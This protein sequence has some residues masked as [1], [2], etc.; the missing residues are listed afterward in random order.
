MLN[1]LDKFRDGETGE[2]ICQS[3]VIQLKGHKHYASRNV[4]ESKKNEVRR[5]IMMEMREL[6]RL[7][8]RFRDLSSKEV[9]V[10]S[11]YEREN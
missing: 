10:E 11:M 3:S 1:I 6:A 9:E 7:F 2:L 8:I 4:E 5:E